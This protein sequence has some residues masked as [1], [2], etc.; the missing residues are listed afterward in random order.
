MVRFLLP[1]AWWSG[2]DGSPVSPTGTSADDTAAPLPGLLHF[3]SQADGVG[4]AILA[5]LL[6]MSLA[7][8]TL[9]LAKGIGLALE[10]RRSRR[11]LEAFRRG[12]DSLENALGE[13][14]F[15]GGEQHA[16]VP[17]RGLPRIEHPALGPELDR[18]QRN[19]EASGR[20]AGGAGFG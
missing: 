15:H 8:W 9:I 5:L 12:T 20:F 1:L 2:C 11:F 3:L 10:R 14:P 19:A 18:P 13:D 4:R 6:A 16:P 17:T 7:S